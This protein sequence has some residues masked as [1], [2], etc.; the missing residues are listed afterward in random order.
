VLSKKKH[1][2]SV[3]V[4]KKVKARQINARSLAAHRAA[5]P[6]ARLLRACKKRCTRVVSALESQ[7]TEVE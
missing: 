1:R 2:H 7:Q 5:K 4:A 3:F 6:Q